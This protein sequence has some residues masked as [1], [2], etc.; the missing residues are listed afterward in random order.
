MSLALVLPA[1]HV[2]TQTAPPYFNSTDTPLAV[3]SLPVEPRVRMVL[4]EYEYEAGGLVDDSLSVE[5]VTP[6]RMTV[7]SP[8]AE[9]IWT[10]EVDTR[11]H[12]I[13]HARRRGRGAAAGLD[14]SRADRPSR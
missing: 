4:R 2:V 9:G 11:A 10:W 5:A 1:H 7:R 6:G 12:T 8:T 3:L 14:F 13:L